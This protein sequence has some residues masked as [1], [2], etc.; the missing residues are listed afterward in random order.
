M[1][2]QLQLSPSAHRPTMTARGPV[3]LR[4]GELDEAQLK[5]YNAAI[6]GLS[7]FGPK[8]TYKGTDFTVIY[9]KL[10]DRA[11]K[12]LE[13]I[14]EQVKPQEVAAMEKANM[15]GLVEESSDMLFE[16]YTMKALRSKVI[17]TDKVDQWCRN[18]MPGQTEQARAAKP[19]ETTLAEI[20]QDL[21]KDK[22]G[23]LEKTIGWDPK[24]A[25]ELLQ[26]MA[27]KFMLMRKRE[28]QYNLVKETK[29]LLWEESKELMEPFPLFSPRR[30]QI[31]AL[32]LAY[33]YIPQLPVGVFRSQ[34]ES[35]VASRLKTPVK[36][37]D[38]ME[39][40]FQKQY[41]RQEYDYENPQILKKEDRKRVLKGIE[42]LNEAAVLKKARLWHPADA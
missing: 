14:C 34:L 2:H 21:P 19:F 13:K 25:H 35:I 38:L 39:N 17:T 16:L 36:Y 28:P 23:K 8:G 10:K 31:A 11:Q 33:T 42:V 15:L 12:Q 40:V 32:A 29:P 22:A 1:L 18:V 41:R 26:L 24:K 4:F 27:A 37:G 7:D 6:Q 30:I 9:T 20:D 5:P 3:P